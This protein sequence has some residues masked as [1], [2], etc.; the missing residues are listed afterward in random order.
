[1]R[2]AVTGSTGFLGRHFV[3]A[4][5]RAGH[6]VKALVR[7]G[8]RVEPSKGLTLVEGDLGT[9]AALA[10]LVS[11]ADVVLHLAALGVQSRDRDAALMA[12]ANVR[13]AV[14]L[15]EMMA[16]TGV[17][18]L[19]VAGTVL[20]YA[21]ED[22]YGASK[23]AGFRALAEAAARLGLEGWYLRL[24]SLYG[25]GDDGQKFLPAAIRA[26][27]ARQPFEMTPGS[28]EREWL[29]VDDAVTALLAAADRRAPAPLQAVDVG[30]GVGLSLLELVR[31][32]FDL[33]GADPGLVKAGA[34]P[35]RAGEVMRLVMEPAGASGLLAWTP[36][37]TLEDGLRALV[38]E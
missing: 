26:A 38:G 8:R 25:P 32:V 3:P 33:A 16:R 18:R 15:A 35:Y 29:H 6:E 7:P 4:A 20:E 23:A 5:L 1:M 11:G 37:V 9:E 28:Q 34:R 10:S 27:R 30:T 31:R 24:A 17:R 19:V 21:P 14:R 36:R 13:G 2:L 12:E 22:P